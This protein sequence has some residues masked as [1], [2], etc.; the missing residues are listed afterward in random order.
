MD[1]QL[2]DL[3]RAG[4]ND[5]IVQAAFCHKLECLLFGGAHQFLP[6]YLRT[7]AVW[8]EDL[9]NQAARLESDGLPVE[10]D[11]PV[12]GIHGVPHK[13]GRV[14]VIVRDLLDG[15]GSPHRA[16]LDWLE[17][18]QVRSDGSMG[19]Y[20]RWKLPCAHALPDVLDLLLGY[21]RPD[22]A[23]QEDIRVRALAFFKRRLI[24]NSFPIMR[25]RVRYEVRAPRRRPQTPDG[26]FDVYAGK[27]SIHRVEIVGQSQEVHEGQDDQALFA[28]T[29]KNS[30]DTK[31]IY[32]AVTGYSTWFYRLHQRPQQPVEERALMIGLNVHNEFYIGPRGIIISHDDGRALGW[33]QSAQNFSQIQ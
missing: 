20:G 13:G 2:R 33:S 25:Q 15:E 6:D 1:E 26:V 10:R 8:L 14:S 19:N 4:R 24:D 23:R 21:C 28:L 18:T 27:S 5:P 29:G 12:F 16:Q 31:R 17:R 22:L 9:T 7:G 30:S 32:N 11:V 3:E